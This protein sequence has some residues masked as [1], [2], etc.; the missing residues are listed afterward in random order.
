MAAESPADEP[1]VRSMDVLWGSV[2]I[3][4]LE[5]D[6]AGHTNENMGWHLHQFVVVGSGSDELRFQS[7]TVSPPNYGPAVDAV[8]VSQLADVPAV[9]EWSVTVIALLLLSALTVVLLWRRRSATR[10]V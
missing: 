8:S 5:F 9:S 3:A 4:Q 10:A 1:N 2:E 6:P 7:T